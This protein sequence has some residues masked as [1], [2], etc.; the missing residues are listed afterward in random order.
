MRTILTL[1][2]SL[3]IV[4][5]VLT[6]ALAQDSNQANSAQSVAQAEKTFNAGNE[7][8]EQ[9]KFAEALIRYKEALVI[10]PNDPSL[11]FNSGLAAYS[12]KDYAQA[13]E[14]W[15]R[16]KTVDSSDW[17]ARAKLIQA[18]Q[19]LARLPERDAERTELFELWKSGKNA[20]LTQQFEYCRDQF[21]VNGKKVMAFEHFELKGDRALRYVFSVLNE[22][23]D[24]EEFR[25]S[26]GS[27]KLTNSVWRE[28]TQP[29]PRAGERLFH[30]DGYFKNGHATYGMYFPE[31]SYDEVR[32][33]V[34]Q[35]LE[36][37]SKPVSSSTVIPPKTKPETEPKP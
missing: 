12:S 11:L 13:A 9:R 26:L 18:Y 37:K 3:L 27:Y 7:L 17:H 23:G 4:A 16:L 28:T 35:I 36:G 29:K 22:A 33:K 14:L 10:L 8:M 30:L 6:D 32:S 21:E 2:L 19:A 24:G 15:K 1:T 25:I 20:E 34:I 5:T 31:P